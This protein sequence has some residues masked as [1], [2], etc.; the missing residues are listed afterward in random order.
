MKKPARQ[1]KLDV[2]VNHIQK[3][4]DKLG[5]S[6]ETAR[7]IVDAALSAGGDEDYVRS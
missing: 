2:Y 4:A 3:V 1:S 7:S 5:C 6:V